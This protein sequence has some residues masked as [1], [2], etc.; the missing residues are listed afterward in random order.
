M[1]F[2]SDPLTSAELAQVEANLSVVTAKIN[3]LGWSW[4]TSE[5]LAYAES[6]DSSDGWRRILIKIILWILD[7]L[8][9]QSG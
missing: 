4:T 1:D 2:T 6:T 8:A 5:T 3:A 9:G 7:Q